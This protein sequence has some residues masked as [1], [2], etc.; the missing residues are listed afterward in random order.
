MPGA[1]VKLLSLDQTRGYAVVLGKLDAGARY[2][3][4]NI[5]T[6]GSVLCFRA[7]SIWEVLSCALE[8]FIMQ[9][10]ERGMA[11]TFLRMGARFWR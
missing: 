10:L 1:F 5:R 8:I 4:I 6:G 9:M 7:I 11:K 2:P 3:P